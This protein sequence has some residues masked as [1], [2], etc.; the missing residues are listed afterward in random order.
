MLQAAEIR[1]LDPNDPGWQ[2]TVLALLK[3]S[4]SKE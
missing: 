1:L 3:A 2:D 4:T